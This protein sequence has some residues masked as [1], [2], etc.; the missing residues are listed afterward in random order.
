MENPLLK[1]FDT[2]FELPPFDKIEIA[3]YLPAIDHAI[4]VSRKEMDA[5]TANAAEPTFENTI[6][7]MEFSG[8]LL[9]RITS[10]LFNLNSAET[11]DD[12]Q[13]VA[14]DAS[15][16]L[17]AFSN[18][19]SQNEKLW[20][21]IK[22]VFEK[23]DGNDL[24]SE[25]Q[26][27]LTKTYKGFIRS[28]ADLNETDKLR[29]KEVS[30]E[31]SK[32]A[33][34][35]GENVLAETNAYEL[36]IENEA[37]LK[38]LP[39]DVI[40][41][42]KETAEKKDK[43][44]KW[45]FTLQGPSYIPLMEHAENR[46]LREELY[47]AYMSKAL[48]G[49]EHDNQEIVR[50]LVSLHAEQASLLGYSTYS[51]FV[52]EERM[53]QTPEKVQGFLKDL[54]DKAMPKAKA[55]YEELKDFA[56][57]LGA[58]HEL[59]RWDWAYYSEKLRKKKY[60]LD[61]ELTKPYFKLE[62]VIDGVFK[63]AEKLFDVSFERNKQLPVYHEDVIAYDVKELSGKVSAVFLADFFP[64]DGKR[65]GAWMTSFR[66]EKKLDGKKVIPQVSIVCN[67]TPSSADAPSL[68][69]FEEVQTLFHEFGHALHGMLAD[70]TYGSLSGT[71]V[72]WDFVELPSQIFE[73]WCYE[74]ECLD[75]FAHHYQT[76][77]L[78][79]E[80]YVQKLKESA[81]YHEAYATVRQISFGLLDLQWHHLTM[82]E[83]A[84]IQDVVG[85]ER[86]AFAATDLFPPVDN[87][88]MSTQFSHIFGGGYASGYYSYKWAEVLDADAFSLFKKNGV[89]DKATATSFKENILSKGGTEH[90]MTLYKR[91]R[92][93]EPTPDALLERAGLLQ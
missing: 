3:H 52:L 51:D 58:D 2:P 27:L 84:K 55:E 62:N 43:S 37:D 20:N 45:I 31:L 54:L 60:D 56:K 10:V 25:Q 38:G 75:L 92:G 59:E 36:V 81:I 19:V 78:I 53:A 87:T 74:K 48:K 66:E 67:F 30:M 88:C 29:Y 5:I 93:M 50:K 41:R 12:L 72:F 40:T 91:F 83:A 61:D 90:P 32:L 7:A 24:N 82:E 77:E 33:L 26:M 76:G 14:R 64:R 69:T 39:K 80:I 15:P 13:G 9:S 86:A 89:F 68:L 71:S 11:S 42:A 17:S 46:A 73:N 85:V 57:S 63:T 18:E 21:R 65:G 23:K 35:F 4:E 28:G 22:K 47:K 49:D 34:Q 1:P 16:K 70:T 8:S 6:E 44:G 79:P